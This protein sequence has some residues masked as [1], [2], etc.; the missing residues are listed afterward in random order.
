MSYCRAAPSPSNDRVCMAYTVCNGTQF[1]S[2]APTSTSGSCFSCII[3]RIMLKCYYCFR[4]SVQQLLG[5]PERTHPDI[6]CNAIIS[7]VDW[8]L[9]ALVFSLCS[10]TRQVT[11][12]VKGAS[13]VSLVCRLCM[14]C[15]RGRQTRFVSIARNAT[16]QHMRYVLIVTAACF[17]SN[18]S[19]HVLTEL[20]M[21]AGSG[22][23]MQQHHCMHWGHI[24][25][26][27]ANKHV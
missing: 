24:S 10:A 25:E 27:C 3:V 20:T 15:A 17:V 21:Y 2:V 13:S 23:S 7:H 4:S 5:L 6:C 1:Q 22:C 11:R 14:R 19:I 12:S 9:I 16:P 8:Q 26:C 18:M